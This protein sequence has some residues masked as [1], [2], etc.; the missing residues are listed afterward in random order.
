[1]DP[2]HIFFK[3]LEI[4][5]DSTFTENLAKEN[6]VENVFFSKDTEYAIT[7]LSINPILSD[8]KLLK[9]ENINQQTKVWHSI[10]DLGKNYKGPD[11][12]VFMSHPETKT[13]EIPFLKKNESDLPRIKFSS[14]N[15]T[16]KESVDF[17]FYDYI[18]HFKKF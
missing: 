1:M 5:Q 11:L 15:V 17:F 9:I 2:T 8:E 16:T 7:G 6:E 3:E 13:V 10:Q 14:C 12:T 4:D 18:S